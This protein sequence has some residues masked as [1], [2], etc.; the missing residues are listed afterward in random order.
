MILSSN[1][2]CFLDITLTFHYL[3]INAIFKHD[4]FQVSN[5]NESIYINVCVC[6]CVSVTINLYLN[7]IYAQFP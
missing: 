3:E 5:K 7:L 2:Y 4:S 6:V 1:N